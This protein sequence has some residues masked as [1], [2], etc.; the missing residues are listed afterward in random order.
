MGSVTEETFRA[1]FKQLISDEYK[2][3]PKEELE[4]RE[5]EVFR[6]ARELMTILQLEVNELTMRKLEAEA[7]IRICTSIISAQSLLVRVDELR[8]VE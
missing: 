3:L 4:K 5:K 6:R 2:D 8:D 7:H 1:L